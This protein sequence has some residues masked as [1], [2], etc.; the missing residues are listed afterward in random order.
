MRTDVIVMGAGII[1]VSIALHLQKR[2]REVVLVDRKAAGEE[3]SYGNAGLIE[4]AS[5]A[6]YA[7]PRDIGSLLKYGF[8]TST[9]VRYHPSFLPKIAPW[10]FPILV[11]L[12][13]IPAR[14]GD[15]RDASAHRTLR[16][17]PCRTRRG[18]QARRP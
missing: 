6:P 17:G 9:E 10:L 14:A 2:G 8:N 4:R 1:G 12:R 18:L 5:I 11:A 16:R 15:T 7:F 13:T 3:T